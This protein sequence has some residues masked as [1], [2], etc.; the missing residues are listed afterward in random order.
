[1]KG[2][3]GEGTEELKKEEVEEEGE[4]DEE[5]E[6]E[7]GMSKT[8]IKIFGK[9]FIIGWEWRGGHDCTYHLAYPRNSG[10]DRKTIPGPHVNQSTPLAWDANHVLCAA[11]GGEDAV[12]SFFLWDLNTGTHARA[13]IRFWDSPPFIESEWA[14]IYLWASSALLW[15]QPGW[16]GAEAKLHVLRPGEEDAEEEEGEERVRKEYMM[17]GRR[18]RRG[19][20]GQ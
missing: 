3:K 10:Q 17:R 19:R 16:R 8:V 7:E 2:E 20:G 15:V 4:V 12:Y 11:D 6:E 9:R 13:E 14:R 18:A 5:E 1:V